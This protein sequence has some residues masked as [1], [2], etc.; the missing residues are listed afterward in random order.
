[1]AWNLGLLGAAGGGAAPAYDHIQTSNPTGNSVQFTSLDSLTDYK[2][3]QIRYSGRT[4][5]FAN[6]IQ[7]YMQFNSASSG[8]SYHRMYGTGSAIQ[9]GGSDSAS[10]IQLGQVLGSAQAGNL[11]GSGVIDILDFASSSKST[12]TRAFTEWFYDNW[13]TGENAFVGGLYDSTAPITSIKIYLNAGFNFLTGSRVSL[14]G[15][16]G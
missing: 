4:S 5:D 3:L 13:S 14:Y 10:F 7:L 15:I 8:Y 11:F 2:H 6:S 1:M 16:K 9:S 12:T